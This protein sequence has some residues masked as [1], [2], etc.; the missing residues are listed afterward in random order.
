MKFENGATFDAYRIIG[1]LGSGGMGEVFRVEHTLTKRQE[2]MKILAG[3]RLRASDQAERFLREIQLQASL[4]HPNIAAVHHA[5]HVDDDLVMVMELVEGTTLRSVLETGRLPFSTALDYASQVLDALD[6]AHQ[7]GVVHRD[8]TPAN[9]LIAPG[10]V[11]KL[12]DFGLAKSPTD[13]RFTQT[14]IVMGSLYYM[15]PEQVRG[16][17]TQDARTDVYSAGVV[18]YEMATG[19]K[20]FEADNPFS[21]MLAHVQQTP[22]PPRNIDPKLPPELDEAILTALAKEADKRFP[23]ARAFHGALEGLSES[24]APA[25]VMTTERAG[26]WSRSRITRYFGAVVFVSAAMMTGGAKRGVAH[27]EIVASVPLL[28]PVVL[29]EAKPAAPEPAA[30]EPAPSTT[31]VNQKSTPAKPRRRFWLRR[32]VGKMMHPRETS[33]NESKP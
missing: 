6:Y 33:S 15:S 21:L 11:V 19:R 26:K 23:S 32:A 24:H 5:F 3:G 10:G 14:G 22:A 28:P 31:P 1:T 7:H 29:T 20:P 25:A 13:L 8:V 17:P 12:T 16:M 9:I 27:Y 18:L 4:S 2:A 30:Q